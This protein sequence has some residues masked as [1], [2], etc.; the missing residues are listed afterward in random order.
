MRGLLLICGGWSPRSTSIT[1]PSP[2]ARVSPLAGEKIL[3]LFL[4][5]CG[6]AAG[7]W[8]PAGMGVPWKKGGQACRRWK[9]PQGRRWEIARGNRET[10][11]QVTL[12]RTR[13]DH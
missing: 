1:C 11:E 10:P 6:D 2:P 4:V 3:A 5:C 12:R 13:N 7:L 8:Q 9:R